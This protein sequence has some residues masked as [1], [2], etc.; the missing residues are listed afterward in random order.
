MQ[1]LLDP[2]F[3]KPAPVDPSPLWDWEGDDE[4]D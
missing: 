2:F 1:N 4:I 3:P